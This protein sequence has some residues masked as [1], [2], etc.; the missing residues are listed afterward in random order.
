VKLSLF[1]SAG[2]ASAPQ[3]TSAL[4]PAKFSTAELKPSQSGSL[5]DIGQAGRPW[6]EFAQVGQLSAMSAMPSLS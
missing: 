2:H 4:V 1:T 6:F 3:C 5:A